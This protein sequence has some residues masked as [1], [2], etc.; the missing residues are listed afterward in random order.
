VK[1]YKLK[2]PAAFIRLLKSELTSAKG[3][4]K[5]ATFCGVKIPS[6]VLGAALYK[7]DGLFEW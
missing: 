1:C 6:G 5:I 3:F 7:P 2:D 4:A